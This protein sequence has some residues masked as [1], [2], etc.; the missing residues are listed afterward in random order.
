MT[1]AHF[2]IQVF[3]YGFHSILRFPSTFTQLLDL[4]LV[5]YTL[6][7]YHGAFFSFVMLSDELLLV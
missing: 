7:Y 5:P 1:L 6:C 3:F 2:S 4:C